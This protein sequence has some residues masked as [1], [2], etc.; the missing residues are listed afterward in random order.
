SRCSERRARAR[1]PSGCS[2][3]AFTTSLDKKT[4]TTRRKDCFESM[5]DDGRSAI[6]ERRFANHRFAT[7]VLQL[8]I[9]ARHCSAGSLPAAVAAVTAALSPS[10]ALPSGWQSRLTSK[11]YI[12]CVLVVR[13]S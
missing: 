13:L 5:I 8:F 3:P 1:E 12:G 9:A 7:V 11:R 4:T 6:E 2:A 10:I